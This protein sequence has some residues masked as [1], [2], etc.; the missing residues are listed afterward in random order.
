M[1]IKDVL[2]EVKNQLSLEK[3]ETPSPELNPVLT[4][5]DPERT[6]STLDS[7]LYDVVYYDGETKQIEL[8]TCSIP[9]GLS[10]EQYGRFFQ[11]R[12]EG[13]CRDFPKNRPQTIDQ[14]K[15]WLS[16]KENAQSFSRLSKLFLEF[17]V[18]PIS[19]TKQLL[20]PPMGR[21]GDTGFL[22]DD[23]AES[24]LDLRANAAFRA[25]KE[26]HD[27]SLVYVNGGVVGLPKEN[28]RMLKKKTES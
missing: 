16:K 9:S 22:L 17:A 6:L 25:Y 23:R 1:K 14:Y 18:Q 10:P 20:T 19:L 3:E 2:E 7:E 12:T 26:K 5:I 27:I 24:L 21:R 28:Y 11:K 8:I 4:G 15:Q 13:E